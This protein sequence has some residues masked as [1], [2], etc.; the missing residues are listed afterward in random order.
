MHALVTS[1]L[2]SAS[3]MTFD[4]LLAPAWKALARSPAPTVFWDHRVAPPL[5]A[6]WPMTPTSTVVRWVYAAGRDSTL[7]DGERI[8]APWARI[9]LGPD[10]APKL[11]TVSK[12]LEVVDTQ[13]VRPLSKVEAEGLKQLVDAEAALRKN[14]LAAVRAGYCGWISM[15]GAIARRLEPKHAAFFAA[16][17]CARR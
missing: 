12:A 11:S 13:G 8:A 7:R 15:N 5:P 1:L 4:D 17:D 9:D 2:L 10:G 14:D 3:P 6:D 16:L